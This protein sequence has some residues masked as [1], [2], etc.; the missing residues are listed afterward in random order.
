MWLGLKLVWRYLIRSPHSVWHI[1]HFSLQPEEQNE[2]NKTPFKQKHKYS[3][4]KDVFSDVFSPKGTFSDYDLL[5]RICI[6]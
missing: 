3:R 5:A 4:E 2:N 6:S 1:S